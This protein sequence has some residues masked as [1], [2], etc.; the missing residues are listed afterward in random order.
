MSELFINPFTQQFAFTAYCGSR[1]VLDA[2]DMT[3]TIEDMVLEFM[4][5]K[6]QVET[7]RWMCNYKMEKDLELKKCYIQE[8]KTRKSNNAAK[9]KKKK[10]EI[11]YSFSN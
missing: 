11:I 5:L 2:G 9:R 10:E 4:S 1:I 8:Y 6:F 7:H 3:V